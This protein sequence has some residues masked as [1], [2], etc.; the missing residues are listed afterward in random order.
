MIEVLVCVAHVLASVDLVEFSL[1]IA[2][3]KHIL[4][5]VLVVLA[6]VSTHHRTVSLSVNGVE[7]S[8]E[9]VTH[10][11]ERA[12]FPSPCHLGKVSMSSDSLKTKEEASEHGE[13]RCTA[14]CLVKSCKIFT[15]SNIHV[16]GE[17]ESQAVGIGVLIVPFE[18]IILS[19]H[20]LEPGSTG[21]L[22]YTAE[23]AHSTKLI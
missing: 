5:S 13:A 20:T 18:A 10:S 9:T 22:V 6:K 14:V 16:R 3:I 1:A 7:H 15:I 21:D 4:N 8:L 17:K 19:E 12:Q 2:N 23:V 11:K